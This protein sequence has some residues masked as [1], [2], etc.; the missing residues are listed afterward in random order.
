MNNFTEKDLKQYVKDYQVRSRE[1]LR[2]SRSRS[3][4]KNESQKSYREY[5][6]HQ[7]MIRNINFKMKHGEW[8]YND[9]P[10]GRMIKQFRIIASGNPDDVGKLVDSFGREYDVPRKGN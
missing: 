6:D 8:L 9:L 1:A 2:R 4:E 10:N 7:A 5:L 3:I